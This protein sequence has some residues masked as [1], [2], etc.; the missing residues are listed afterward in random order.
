[1]TP[2]TMRRAERGA[3]LLWAL[4]LVFH[5]YGLLPSWGD[6]AV[7]WVVIPGIAASGFAMWFAAPLRKAV[8]RIRALAP[9]P[10]GA[11]SRSLRSSVARRRDDLGRRLS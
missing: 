4:V 3:H 2:R 10:F 8:R 9:S 7:R 1:M 11:G 6:P 5:V